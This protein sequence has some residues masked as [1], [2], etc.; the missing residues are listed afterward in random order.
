[1]IDLSFEA[2]GCLGDGRLVD[3]SDGFEH[4]SFHDPSQMVKPESILCEGVILG[5]ASKFASVCFDDIEVTCVPEFGTVNG[6]PSSRILGDFGFQLLGW[7]AERDF[8][9]RCLPKTRAISHTDVIAEEPGLF[10]SGMCNQGLFRG[11]F[12]FEMISQELLQ[13][14]LDVLGLVLWASETQKEVV[15]ISD[16]PKPA[17]IGII[18]ITVSDP[19]C[20]VFKGFQRFLICPVFP[21]LLDLGD[22]SDVILVPPSY[23]SFGVL[24]NEGLFNEFIESVQVD[25]R[26]EWAD[27]PALRCPAQRGSVAPFFEI[28]SLEQFLDQDQESVI[29]DLLAEDR[30]QDGVVNIVETSLDITLD[31]PSRTRPGMEDV[32]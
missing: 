2:S 32:L 23:V 16:I 1:V 27:N 30:Q 31:E 28:S 11:H 10:G 9:G 4:G 12:Q 8:S 29:S 21:K 25:I 13:L 20:F 5:H 14:D 6:L 22:E 26:E 7:H 18:L 17:I 3:M 19:S 15:G 24:W